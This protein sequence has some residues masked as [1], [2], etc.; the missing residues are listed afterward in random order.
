MALFRGFLVCYL[1]VLVVYTGAV[2]SREGWGLFQVFFADMA[3]MAWPGQ[4]NTDFTGF[5]MLSALWT[6]WRDRFRPRALALAILA[7]FGGM[8]FLSIFLL[9]L[10]SRAKGDMGQV[11]LG[12]RRG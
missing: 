7:F 11:L 1:V 6:A 4:F 8:L 10:T 5:L 3:R 9:V 2:I 12:E